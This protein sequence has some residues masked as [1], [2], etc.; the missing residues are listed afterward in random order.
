MKLIDKIKVKLGKGTVIDV[1]DIQMILSVYNSNQDK[2]DRIGRNDK[3]LQYKQ[4]R[5]MVEQE[6]QGLPDNLLESYEAGY[7][8]SIAFV[9]GNYDGLARALID[10]W[11]YFGHIAGLY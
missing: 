4:L 3:D 11:L 1:S 9:H 6:K 7:G 10:K 8:T 5:C 2:W